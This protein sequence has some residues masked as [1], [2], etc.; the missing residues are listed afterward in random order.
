M[1]VFVPK[2]FKVVLIHFV[3]SIIILFSENV[4]YA[5]SSD[6]GYITGIVVGNG[7]MLYFYSTGVREQQAAC[8][9]LGGRYVLNA[10]TLG[11]QS[12]MS[13]ILAAYVTHQKVSVIGTGACAIW[14]DSESVSMVIY[15]N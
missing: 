9:T 13:T 4:A 14:G 6:P 12:I 8:A 3:L 15:S 5:G 7:G 11:G 1:E 2:I 10:S